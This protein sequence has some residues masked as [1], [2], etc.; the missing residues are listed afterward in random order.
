MRNAPGECRLRR[1]WTLFASVGSEALVV[2]LRESPAMEAATL[3][4]ANLD[5]LAPKHCFA[6]PIEQERASPT[7][8]TRLS[9]RP[10]H[11]VQSLAN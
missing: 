11:T 6:L 4:T 1:T 2:S 10:H 8:Q 9:V 7:E 5:S 3:L